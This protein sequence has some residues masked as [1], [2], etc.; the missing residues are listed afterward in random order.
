MSTQLQT[1]GIINY[2][3]DVVPATTEE[4][5]QISAAA[6][7]PILLRWRD[8]CPEGLIDI[9]FIGFLALCVVLHLLYSQIDSKPH[10]VQ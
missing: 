10:R 1:T 6:V 7:E 4:M 3:P 8:R 5:E 9:A 2:V